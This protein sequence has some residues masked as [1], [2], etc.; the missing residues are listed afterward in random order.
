MSAAGEHKLMVRVKEGE[1]TMMVQLLEVGGGEK[2]LLR[3]QPAK[4]GDLKQALARN[5]PFQRPAAGDGGGRIECCC[6]CAPACRTGLGA[7]PEQW[8]GVR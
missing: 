8:E 1:P 6:W 4:T 5:D 3:A 2:S 7:A